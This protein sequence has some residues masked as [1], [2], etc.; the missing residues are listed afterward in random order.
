M[1]YCSWTVACE[2]CSSLIITT[3]L[4]AK[5]CVF[6]PKPYIYVSKLCIYVL[7]LRICA[8]TLNTGCFLVVCPLR[9]RATYGAQQ[10]DD[11]VAVCKTL[12]LIEHEI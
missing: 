11:W 8:E 2:D 6:M 10:Y 7:K 12:R 9:L 3:Y 4:C 5:A 1:N